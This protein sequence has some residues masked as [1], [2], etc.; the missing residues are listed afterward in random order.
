MAP[1]HGEL[2]LPQIIENLALECF[3]VDV[4]GRFRSPE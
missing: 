4:H 2:G 1:E 3:E